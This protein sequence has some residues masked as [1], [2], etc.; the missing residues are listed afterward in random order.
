MC[1]IWLTII[2]ARKDERGFTLP[3]LLTVIAI[4]G[5]LI[6]IAIFIWLGILEQR[7]VDA[8]AKQFAADLRLAHSS[9]TNQLTDW[10]LIYD[11][12]KPKYH[13]VKLKQS[14]PPDSCTDPEAERVISRELPEGTAVVET[15]NGVDAAPATQSRFNIPNLAA[16]GVVD[17][18]TVNNPGM[19]TS[20]IEFN[21]DGS[22]YVYNGPISGLKIGSVSNPSLCWKITT[23][24]STSRVKLAKTDGCN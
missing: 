1:K 15:S 24:S 19:S 23:T 9:A 22:S 10:R 8:A 2:R 7:R 4:L 12:N 18:S 14:C 17:P 6:A 5:I 13:L 11:E 21:S 20:T 3:E 16:L